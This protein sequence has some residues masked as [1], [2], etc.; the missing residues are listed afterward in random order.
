MQDGAIQVLKQGQSVQREA[1]VLSPQ[2]GLISSPVQGSDGRIKLKAILMPE[3]A[4]GRL[5]QIESSTL[6]TKVRIEAAHFSGSN[7]GESWWVELGL[8]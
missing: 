6:K 2:T 8:R 7:F 3:L 5:V 4:P 1:I